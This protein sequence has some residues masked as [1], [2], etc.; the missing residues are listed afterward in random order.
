MFNGFYESTQIPAACV[1]MFNSVDVDAVK[2]VVFTTLFS[3]KEENE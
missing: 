2:K 3:K 1:I